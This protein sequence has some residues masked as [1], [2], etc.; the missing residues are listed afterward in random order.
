MPVIND[1]RELCTERRG[2]FSLRIRNAL[3]SVHDKQG[4]EEFSN[5]LKGCGTRLFATDGTAD[6]LESANINANRLSSI[7]GFVSLLGGRVKTLHPA[8][9]AAILSRP[10]K[11]EDS[12][13]LTDLGVP[14]FDMVISNL[15]PFEELMDAGETDL[16]KLMENIDIGGISLTRAA[17]KNYSHVAVISDKK[18]YKPVAEEMEQ[19]QGT[20]SEATLE[21]LCVEAFQRVSFYDGL[22]SA[23]LGERFGTYPFPDRLTMVGKKRSELKYGENPYQ[24][25][26]AYIIPG[27]AGSILDA[28]IDAGK[29][30]SYNNLLDISNAVDVLR[31]FSEPCCAVVK[32][33]NPCGVATAGGIEQALS[34]AYGAD[35]LSAYGSV[36]GVNRPLTRASAEYLADKFVEV[37]LAPA[38]EEEALAILRRKKKLRIMT[39][40]GL[41]RHAEKKERDVRRISGGFLVQEIVVPDVRRENLKV[42]TQ[43]RPTPQELDSM[44]FAN[45][46]VRH[47]WSNAIVLADG[48]ATVGIGAGQSSRVDAVKLAVMKSRGKARGSVLA[49]DAFFPFRDGV[50]E[51]ANGGIHA[52]IQ[53]GGSIRDD[54]V[55]SAAD[56]HRIAM[57]FTGTRLF[58][59]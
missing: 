30:L 16:G 41:N 31:D 44:I 25:G 34:A 24:R 1:G 32:H 21:K 45:R 4:L 55:I 23:A 7:T 57:V 56:E 19:S 13:Q 8:I 28:S 37:V 36:I 59:H 53:P 5:V 58:R 52:I 26:A 27:I 29:G 46:V 54:E 33:A 18:Q 40:P 12:R 3:I 48:S 20:V 51:A 47:L 42:V 39:F 2:D 49:S 6:F 11:E 9:F 17:A 10:E 50:D 15:Y 14:H 22:I 35:S 38:F 43:A